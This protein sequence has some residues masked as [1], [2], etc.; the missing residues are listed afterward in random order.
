MKKFPK[1]GQRL[2]SV[3]RKWH[4]ARFEDDPHFDYKNHVHV[5]Q[6]PE[7]GGKHQLE[8]LMGEFIAQDWDL[9][10]PLW[11]MLIVENYEDED[12]AECAL[13]VRGHHTLADGQGFVIS[14]LYMTSYHD[15]LV[16]M[17]SSSAEAVSAAETGTVT[18][19]SV[20]PLLKPLDRLSEPSNVLIAPLVQL[21]LASVFWISYALTLAVSFGYSTYHLVLDVFLCA[22]TAWRV[23]ML[24]APQPHGAARTKLKEFASSASMSMQDVRTCQKAFSGRRMG[25]E[26]DGKHRRGH[27][28]VN[29][30]M[31]AVMADVL[32]DEI[33]SKPVDF[34]L[35]GR[36]KRALAKVLPSPIGFFIPISI[37]SPGDWS[38]RNL[39]T[40]WLVYLYPS[41][42]SNLPAPS[43]P[44]LH[45]HIHTCRTALTSLKHSLWPRIFFYIIQATGQVPVLYFGLTSVNA[46]KK[47]VIGPIVDASLR[48]FP[49]I[50]TNVPG[51]AKK[52]V[53]LEG[54]QVV[55]WTALPPQGGKG[56]VGMGLISYAGS[57]CISVAADRV[58]ASAGVARRL[59]ERFEE[60]FREYV[61][62]AEQV[63]DEVKGE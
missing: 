17:M 45:Q 31:C 49:V 37:R 42:P 63:L 28:T 41:P 62:A 51:P 24:T 54:M 11:E 55:R 1:Y 39:S 5:T 44:T 52:P 56:T 57:M 47:R 6:L 25:A 14:Q 48:S 20:H 46:L 3:G 58:P 16:N 34:T 36:V 19:S 21:F 27:V 22:C 23:E 4:G 43:V 7:P 35:W 40:G 50:L 32:G 10:K 33:R 59:C 53:T 26:K 2:T 60:R 12:G 9:S 30:V 8:T 13:I 15:E 18:P 29:D 38:M 61:R